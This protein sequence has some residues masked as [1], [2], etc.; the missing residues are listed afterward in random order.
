M[1]RYFQKLKNKKGFTMIELIVVI[2]VIAALTAIMIPLMSNNGGIAR[3][4][5]QAKSFY[6]AAQDIMIDYKSSTHSGTEG[7]YSV[8]GKSAAA[9]DI[10]TGKEET[11]VFLMLETASEQGLINLTVSVG[12]DYTCLKSD[13]KTDAALLGKLN[14]AMDESTD[15]GYLYAVIDNQCR[16]V[17][18]FWTRGD[19]DYL[20]STIIAGTDI[21]FTQMDYIGDEVVGAY[22]AGLALSG[23]VFL[24]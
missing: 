23:Q 11:F 3:A 6:F 9:A 12:E 10:S 20:I 7:F 19:L 17:S 16:V 2:A 13:P 14:R 24:V 4:Q 15:N 1:I 21:L 22:P 18:S 5:A 8:E